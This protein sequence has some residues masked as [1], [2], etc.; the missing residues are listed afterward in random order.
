MAAVFDNSHLDD[1][2]KVGTFLTC[3]T[4]LHGRVNIFYV[5]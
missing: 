4:C 3:S 2:M 5:S 1:E